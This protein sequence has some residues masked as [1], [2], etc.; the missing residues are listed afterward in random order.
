MLNGVYEIQIVVNVCDSVE[1]TASDVG[2]RVADILD[3]ADYCCQ[4]QSACILPHARVLRRVDLRRVSASVT[5]VDV[6]GRTHVPCDSVVCSA[7][8]STRLMQP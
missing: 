1:Y 3:S 6:Q 7:R 4:C 8:C 2:R 5:A